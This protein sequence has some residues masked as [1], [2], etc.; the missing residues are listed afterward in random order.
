MLSCLINQLSCLINQVFRFSC[1]ARRAI[2]RGATAVIFD[3]TENK[4][5]AK[6]V[7]LPL[8]YS[9]FR[10]IDLNAPS[11]PDVLFVLIHII[12]YKIDSFRA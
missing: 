3:V 8:L 4:N 11:G 5:A 6:Q 7:S 9:R 10:F 2:Q 1:Q 12:K